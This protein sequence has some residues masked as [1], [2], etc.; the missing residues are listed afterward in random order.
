MADDLL[1]HEG[2]NRL[3]LI[4]AGLPLMPLHRGH[5]RSSSR[6][7]EREGGGILFIFFRS[8]ES[9]CKKKSQLFRRM[10]PLCVRV[11]VAD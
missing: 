6:G 11:L 5:G 8:S 2:R 7:K 4:Q 10:P 1:Q 9:N 3:K